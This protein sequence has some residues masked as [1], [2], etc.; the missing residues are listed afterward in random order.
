MTS[1]QLFGIGLLSAVA[2]MAFIMTSLAT[3]W[4]YALFAWT[5]AIVLT[6][7]IVIGILLVGGVSIPEFLGL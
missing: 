4:R 1:L 2:T 3:S 6:T 5:M 7:V